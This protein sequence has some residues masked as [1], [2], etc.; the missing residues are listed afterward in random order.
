MNATMSIGQLADRTGFSVHT[1]RFYEKAGI[2]GTD[3]QR[4]AAGRRVYTEDD[5]EWM[6]VCGKFRD[7]GMPLAT[8]RQ[9]AELCTREGTEPERLELL[10]AHQRRVREQ[11]AALT[12]CLEIIDF[13]VDFYQRSLAAGTATGL[14]S[15]VPSAAVESQ[16]TGIRS[17]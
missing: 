17:R 11:I 15:A 6:T 2:F 10:R 4:D 3:V 1:L 13:K 14:W 12:N 7:S 5:V 9:Y 16:G 8:I